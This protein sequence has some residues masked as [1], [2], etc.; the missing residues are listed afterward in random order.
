MDVHCH[1]KYGIGY[2][3][4]FPL[5]TFGKKYY[6]RTFSRKGIAKGG[7]GNGTEYSYREARES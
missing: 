5:V 7:V 1:G 6:E 3:W 4:C 2:Y